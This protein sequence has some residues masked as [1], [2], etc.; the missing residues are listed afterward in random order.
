MPQ[1]PRLGTE[2]RAPVHLPDDSGGPVL[3]FAAAV[4]IWLSGRERKWREERKLSRLPV[5]MARDARLQPVPPPRSAAAGFLLRP[6]IST[7]EKPVLVTRARTDPAGGLAGT[8]QRRSGLGGPREDLG[9]QVRRP[10][11]ARWGEE[12]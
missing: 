12:K 4:V 2:A 9:G 8:S 7:A 10:R 5:Y 6:E 3:E 11:S 1:V